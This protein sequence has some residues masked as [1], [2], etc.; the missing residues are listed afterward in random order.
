[1]KMLRLFSFLALLSL[2]VVSCKEEPEETPPTEATDD[3]GRV[4][5]EANITES[6]TLSRTKKYI[7]RNYV[8]VKSGVTLTIESGTTIFADKAS[9]ATLIIEQGAKIVAEGTSSSPIVFTSAQPKGSRAH[10]D[11][12]G[13]VIMGKAPV[14]RPAGERT[15]EGGIVGTYGGSDANDNSGVLKY[16]RIE[17]AGISLSTT[18]NSEINGLT[19]YAVGK[20]TKIEYVQ[21]SYCGDDA[22]EWFGGTVDAKYLISHRTWD[23]DFDTDFGYTGNVQFGVALRDPAVSDQSTSNGFESDNFNPGTPAT[24]NENGLPLT[25]PKFAN[26][27]VFLTGASPASLPAGHKHGSGMHLRRN[28][29]TSCYNSVFVGHVDGFR[30][31]GTTTYD[32]YN[33]GTMKIEGVYLVNNTNALKEASSVI[34]A[35]FQSIFNTTANKNSIITTANYA[36]AKLHSNAFNLTAPNFQPQAG[37]PLLTST[38]A[39][40][41]PSSL[42]QAN[43]I[44]AFDGTNNWT[45]GWANFDPQNTDY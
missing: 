28:T 18:A 12:G 5:I 3:K 14:N 4:I 44:G 2:S 37:S 1:M 11:W 24:G 41:V 39:A 27:S 17:F 21:V 36:D 38:N 32:N 7:L 23:D 34:L 22:F 33:A 6:R 16:V 15:P 31:D 10:G 19:M 43:Y 26:M 42:T 20:G 9:K 8:Y 13:I 30:L 40:T 45:S 25:A 35:N 29:A